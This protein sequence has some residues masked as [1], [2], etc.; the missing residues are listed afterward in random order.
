MKKLKS[1]DE[2][3]VSLGDGAC[4]VRR[5]VA[6]IDGDVVRVCTRLEYEATLAQERTARALSFNVGA[7]RAHAKSG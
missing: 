3:D 6:A 4:T 5:I 2:I 1:G 7:R